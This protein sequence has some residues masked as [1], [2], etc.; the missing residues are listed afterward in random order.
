MPAKIRASPLLQ[1]LPSCESY[2]GVVK[3]G[4]SKSQTGDLDQSPSSLHLLH[5]L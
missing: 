3:L 1:G 2:G 5:L 4:R